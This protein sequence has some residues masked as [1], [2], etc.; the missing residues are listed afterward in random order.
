MPRLS[1]A[2]EADAGARLGTE[3]AAG[4]RI[5]FANQLRGLAALSVVLSHLGG[6]FVLM[7]PMVGWFTSMPEVHVG[8]TA[9]LQLTGRTYLN[10]GALGVSVFFL[11][12]GFVIPF[13][14]RSQ[15]PGGFLVARSLRIFPTFWAALAV[16]WLLVHVQSLAT[17]RGMAFGPLTYVWNAL[18]L[19]SV[20][21]SS[22]VDLV[23]WTLAIEV[24]FY[25]LMAMLRPAVLR[26][27]M[28]PFFVV[29]AA[30]IA[31]AAAQA[32]GVLPVVAQLADEP[33]FLGYMLIGTV[34]HYRLTGLIR[35]VPAAAAILG[36]CGLFLLCWRL[37]PM[38]NQ[39]QVI[40]VNYLYG[41]AIFGMAYAARR[42]FR[43]LRWID[44]LADVSYPLYL[45]HSVVGYSVMALV[46]HG[47]GLGYGLALP[48]GFTAALLV[49]TAIHLVVERPSTSLGRRLARRLSARRVA[50]A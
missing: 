44:A 4:G 18:L 38:R 25:L 11:I 6:V 39:F 50:V 23:N 46:M 7:G 29:S 40:A 14:L 3:P 36:L 35:S 5:I 27:R 30:A 8:R 24:L 26:G 15:R 48:I 17:G 32:H 37:G 43:P 13:S 2:A 10:F 47:L 20:T 12:S 1:V 45:V 49:A 19:D 16:E 41:L 31:I 22:V 28:L 9:I 42:R 21:G 33:M 34:F